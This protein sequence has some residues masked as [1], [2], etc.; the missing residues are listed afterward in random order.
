MG[1][2]GKLVWGI[3]LFAAFYG[4]AVAGFAIVML[5]AVKAT[6]I[7]CTAPDWSSTLVGVCV[8]LLFG[9]SIPVIWIMHKK[10]NATMRDKND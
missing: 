3:M 1:N 4:A 6:D 2:I 9:C 10:H 5:V 7:F 8:G